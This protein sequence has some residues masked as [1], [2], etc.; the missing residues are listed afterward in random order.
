MDRW[1]GFTEK[2]CYFCGHGELFATN[3]HYYFCPDCMAL[4][5][6]L[7]I[8]K[9]CKHIKYGMPV[10]FHSPKYKAAKK[11]LHIRRTF[12]SGP[13]DWCCSYCGGECLADGW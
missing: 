2:E 7:I 4:F 5:T 1:Y 12:Q 13:W 3:E 10:A 8:Q 9:S 6:F 11:K